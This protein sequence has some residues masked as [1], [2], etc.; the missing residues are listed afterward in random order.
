M[1]KLVRRENTHDNNW[2]IC[3]CCRLGAGRGARIFVCQQHLHF[4]LRIRTE[5]KTFFVRFPLLSFRPSLCLQLATIT[6]TFSI[7][8]F[9]RRNK[10]AT[11][12]VQASTLLFIALKDWKFQLLFY[13]FISAAPLFRSQACWPVPGNWKTFCCFNANWCD[14]SCVSGWT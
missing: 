14:L 4:S 11:I 1:E 12:S 3:F 13:Y 10:Q 8:T 9:C 6:D 2:R 7:I 5:A